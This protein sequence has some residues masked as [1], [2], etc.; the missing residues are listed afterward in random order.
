MSL[1]TSF[2]RFTLRALFLMPLFFRRDADILLRAISFFD[3]PDIDAHYFAMPDT[4]P[5]DMIFDCFRLRRCPRDAI[6]ARCYLSAR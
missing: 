6:Y 2:R 3:M 4:I 5:R 1:L